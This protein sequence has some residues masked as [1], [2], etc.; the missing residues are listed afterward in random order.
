MVC[1]KSLYAFHIIFNDLNACRQKGLMLIFDSS[2]RGQNEVVKN[3][4]T[5]VCRTQFHGEFEK[6]NHLSCSKLF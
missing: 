4:W 6:T 5:P 2:P 1:K 3:E